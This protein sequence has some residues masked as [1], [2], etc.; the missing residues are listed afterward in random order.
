MGA[1]FGEDGAV[2]DYALLDVG[3]GA[4]LERFGARVT[5][6][7]SHGVLRPRRTHAAWR[8]ADLRFDRDRGWQA[9]PEVGLDPWTI[10]VADLELGLRPTEAGQVGL[11]PEH[12]G[13]LAWL[14]E[15]VA[16]RAS[17]SVDPPSVLH[18]F[19]STGLATLAMARAGAAV[20][21]V[22][23][24]RPAVGWARENAHRNGLSDRPIRWLVD[25]A[26]AFVAREARRGRRYDGIVLDPPSYGH[27]DGGRAWR[28]ETDL[29]ALLEACRAVTVDDGF[30]LLT[31]HTEAFTGERLGA[32]VDAAWA[33][34]PG[35]TETG[36]LAIDSEAGDRLELGAFARRDARR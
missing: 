10:R 17:A 23:A 32:M 33:G 8:E 22:D 21:H 30:V 4:R 35:R 24:S 28:I 3:D 20:A 1:G 15:Q 12:I 9:R 16:R 14:T 34:L 36:D 26:P 25:D 5:D 13:S 31:A 7:P 2:D 29:P 6:R 18:L 19:A 11:F 27:G